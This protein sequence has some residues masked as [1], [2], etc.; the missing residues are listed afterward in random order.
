MNNKELLQKMR[1]TEFREN[2]G[3]VL[4]IINIM[5]HKY[6]KLT[7]VKSV[8]DEMDESSFLDCINFLSEEEY[9]RLRNTST[10]LKAELS[11]TD[12]YELEAKLTSKGIRLIGGE[13][14]DQMVKA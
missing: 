9:I 13:I 7:S 3:R 10:K 6:E 2:N 8:L 5:R 4:R 1:A 12:Y 11:D 14:T